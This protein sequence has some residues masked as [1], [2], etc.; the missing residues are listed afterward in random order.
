MRYRGSLI[1]RPRWRRNLKSVQELNRRSFF[2]SFLSSFFFVSLLSSF[3]ASFSLP[4]LFAY[5]SL[6]TERE[7]QSTLSI[8]HVRYRPVDNALTVTPGPDKDT[9]WP[10]D[11]VTIPWKPGQDEGKE[12]RKYGRQTTIEK[13]VRS[14]IFLSFT[15]C[16]LSRRYDSTDTKSAKISQRY[17][18]HTVWI[19]CRLCVREPFRESL[20]RFSFI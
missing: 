1:T 4:L 19:C 14:A 7:D 6:I 17:T 8:L 16:T 18:E 5:P 20:C 15:A 12:P 13:L 2:R 10:C 9:T 11:P 3:L